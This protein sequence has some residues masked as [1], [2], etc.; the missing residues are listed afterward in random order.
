VLTDEQNLVGT[1]LHAHEE[2][3]G[4][5]KVYRPAGF[6]FPPARGRRGYAFNPDHTGACI[7]IAARDGTMRTSCTWRLRNSGGGHE[8]EVT[9][10]DGRH[11]ILPL[12]SVDRERLVLRT[13]AG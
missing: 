9:F 6:D 10:D 13:P 12:V 2:D 8:I 5:E 1:W 7:G 3:T 4:T 11:E